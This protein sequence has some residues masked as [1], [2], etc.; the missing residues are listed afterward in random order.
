[1][2]LC[3]LVTINNDDFTLEKYLVQILQNAIKQIG[4]C[5]DWLIC[6]IKV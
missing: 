2:L 4:T 1:M 3:M 5:S 6:K